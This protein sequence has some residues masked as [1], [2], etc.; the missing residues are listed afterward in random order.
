MCN[1][2]KKNKTN[3]VE[4]FFVWT[5]S[6]VYPDTYLLLTDIFN[7]PPN[8][9]KRFGNQHNRSPG[10]LSCR[11]INCTLD[12]WEL[13]FSPIVVVIPTHQFLLIHS[14]NASMLLD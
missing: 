8:H 4:P 1:D 14:L 11:Y 2:L 12:S 9:N 10:P 3:V 6:F 7:C 13:P 5:N